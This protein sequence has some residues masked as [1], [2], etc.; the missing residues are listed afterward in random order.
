M[1][2]A[3]W[4]DAL[5]L[6]YGSEWDPPAMTGKML[7]PALCL[8]SAGALGC[9][10]L[11]RFVVMAAAFEVLH[12]AALT[13]DDVIDSAH[14]RRGVTS[15][16]VLWD[17]HAAVLGGDFLVARATLLLAKYE[18]CPLITSVVASIC[19]M[20]QG[21]LRTLG[22][23]PCSFAEEDCIQL[24]EDKTA[25]LFASTCTGPSY[26]LGASCRDALHRY[27]LAF[28]TAF[29]LVDD[30]LDL[31]RT[32]AE[33]GKP[34]C[35]DLAEG[36]TTLPIL[37]MREA[38]DEAGRARLEQMSGTPLSA[39]DRQ[40]VLVQLEGTGARRRTGGAA[41]KYLDAARGALETLPQSPYRASMEGLL[42]FVL[43]R[44]S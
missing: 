10:D 22:R 30:I 6:V 33:L 8:L 26:I 41:R 19:Q 44:V 28:G 14:L 24:A 40:W 18:S 20:A 23:E 5:R 11:D 34:S 13:H 27:G 37:Y 31:S 1:V 4:T 32:E 38:L 29:Q 43:V 3:Q 17:D 15:L 21:E 9:E 35:G 36:K 12:L 16:N 42:E 2:R 25:S 39:D 7:R